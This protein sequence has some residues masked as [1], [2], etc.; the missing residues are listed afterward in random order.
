M[1]TSP[2]LH[3]RLGASPGSSPRDA[4]RPSG[5]VGQVGPTA[6]RCAYPNLNAWAAEDN[7]ALGGDGQL[8]GCGTLVS[9]RLYWPGALERATSCSG[10]A[11]D[12]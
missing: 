11:S 4:F 8:H 3:A 6:L 12:R 5:G 9:A 7:Y 2:G 1:P 10:G